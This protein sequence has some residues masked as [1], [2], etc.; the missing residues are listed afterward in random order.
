MRARPIVIG[1]VTIA[2]ANQ[3]LSISA[4]TKQN[5]YMLRTDAEIVAGGHPRS[6]QLR[7]HACPPTVT[8]NSLS[9]SRHRFF[10]GLTLSPIQKSTKL[11]TLTNE[12]HDGSPRKSGL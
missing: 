8:Y 2:L 7:S 3:L 6:K 12:V 5:D 1:H 10:V 11:G 4:C 9:F